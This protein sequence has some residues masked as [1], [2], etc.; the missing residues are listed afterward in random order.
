MTASSLI[1]LELSLTAM[2]EDAIR[3]P[4]I[5]LATLSHTETPLLSGRSSETKLNSKKARPYALS[6]DAMLRV[7]T[8][9]RNGPS[10]ISKFNT[11]IDWFLW[12]TIGIL[13]A[14]STMAS[15]VAVLISFDGKATPDW[16]AGI[17]LNSMLSWLSTL[18]RSAMLIPISKGIAQL[19][20]V[21]FSSRRRLSDLERFDD[22]SRGPWGSLVLLWRLKNEIR[23]AHFVMMGAIATVLMLGLDPFVQ[24]IV[25]YKSRQVPLTNATSVVAISDYYLESGTASFQIGQVGL[26][27]K[28]ALYGGIFQSATPYPSFKCSS[29]SCTWPLYSSLA[30]CSLC[31]DLTPQLTLRC[32]P[33][34]TWCNVTLPYDNVPMLEGG[35]AQLMHVDT[36]IPSL[37]YNFTH[38]LAKILGIAGG[39]M[40][41][42]LRNDSK[43]LATECVLV[44]CVN[45]Y[46][47]AVNAGVYSEEIVSSWTNYTED[48]QVIERANIT[49]QPPETFPDGSKQYNLELLTFW[50]MHSYLIDFL[51][52]NMTGY[53]G[54]LIHDSD[55]AQAFWEAE[56]FA[57]PLQNLALGMTKVIR[58]TRFSNG[59]EK[60][61]GIV[62][63][64]EIYVTV[65]W[66]WLSLPV[67]L[68][69]LAVV[70]FVGALVKTREVAG[71]GMWRT[72]LLALLLHGL[73]KDTLDTAR[74][75]TSSTMEG[76]TG[77]GNSQTGLFDVADS[78]FF[79]GYL[80]PLTFADIG[81]FS[82]NN[83]LIK[84]VRYLKIAIIIGQFSALCK[85]VVCVIADVGKSEL[86]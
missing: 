38:P 6:S 12:E 46:R 2:D 53:T 76:E 9:E 42:K 27:M 57:G 68:L 50:S 22:A 85:K 26:E 24:Q 8:G 3:S 21:W 39:F 49:L 23:N 7:S 20:W 35:R 47:S 40:D 56:S 80:N 4:P 65:R 33:R 86:I 58:D 71:L 51:S 1:P 61:S 74:D 11:A 82:G 16:P 36:T 55:A 70:E 29:G 64:N 73:S 84:A 45:T 28:A 18:T 54:K 34:S 69:F 48:P 59:P 52:G 30:I 37:S 78:L 10:W 63:I 19:K 25:A 72:S 14:I 44:P 62:W 77:H 41:Y 15:M 79:R 75:A 13:V 60:S 81:Y 83:T 67:L 17:T 66:L 32:D 31:T 5:H 43:L